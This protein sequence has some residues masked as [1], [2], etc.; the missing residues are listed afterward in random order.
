MTGVIINL[1][2]N[3]T[4]YCWVFCD[5]IDNRI[6]LEKYSYSILS[7]ANDHEELTI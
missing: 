1:P 2:K 3:K 4:K 5:W 7:V 6:E